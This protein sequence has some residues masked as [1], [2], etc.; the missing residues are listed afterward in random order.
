VVKDELAELFILQSTEMEGKTAAQLT[1]ARRSAN[2]ASV[3]AM[4]AR[5][6]QLNQAATDIQRVSRGR[7]ARLRS[8]LRR[9]ELERSLAEDNV[10]D[11]TAVL[12]AAVVV[13]RCGRGSLHRTACCDAAAELRAGV[14]AIASECASTAL[15]FVES[16][17]AAPHATSTDEAQLEP[18]GS[19]PVVR[20]RGAR[21]ILTAL[22]ELQRRGEL[23]SFSA[24]SSVLGVQ[25]ENP[26]AVGTESGSTVFVPQEA[27]ADAVARCMQP[28]NRTG[29]CSLGML[30]WF[31]IACD[32]SSSRLAYC[33]RVLGM[34]G[35]VTETKETA[36]DSANTF[37]DHRGLALMVSAHDAASPLMGLS[38]LN[39]AAWSDQRGL[40]NGRIDSA[41]LESRWRPYTSVG[42]LFEEE[43]QVI[44][45]HETVDRL[46]LEMHER[47]TF[48]DVVRLHNALM[49]P[50]EQ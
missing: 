40:L 22:A 10:R 9:T 27:I 46:D 28:P 44:A 39:H 38:F 34:N 16:D 15:A 48:D 13:Q 49:E 41:V 35:I 21:P 24:L 20:G 29:W 45:R 42:E 1:M 30:A 11:H 43:R 19:D 37:P 26:V 7:A 3:D 17:A 23:A 47:N 25:G 14:A 33:E 31:Q 12:A 4:R 5:A 36:V 18:I 50:C 8:R 2:Q 32:R 6:L